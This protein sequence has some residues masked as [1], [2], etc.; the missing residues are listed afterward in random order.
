LG[1]LDGS[2]IA[3]GAGT[4]DDE[5]ELGHG[6]IGNKGLDAEEQALWVLDAITHLN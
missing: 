3:A 6:S 4:D 2:D 5:I 1:S